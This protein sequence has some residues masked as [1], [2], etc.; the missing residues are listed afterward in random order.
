MLSYRRKISGFSLLEIIIAVGVFAVAVS[1][2]LGLLPALSRQ[3]GS[4]T[5]TL[6]ALRLPDALRVE[7]QRMATAGGFDSLAGETKSLAM[8]LLDTCLLVATR[9]A[10]RLHAL[11]YQ[12][13]LI[14]DQIAEDSKYFLVEV[15]SFNA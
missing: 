9:D 3:A 14:A 2:M 10:A 6:N 4:S 11:N 13:P 1:A 15:W 12:P 7:L 5:D 8:P